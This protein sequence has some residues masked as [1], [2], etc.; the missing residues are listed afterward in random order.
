M[1]VILL[2]FAFSLLISIMLYS[3]FN[4]DSDRVILTLLTAI[5]FV[6]LGFITKETISNKKEELS[7]EF[8]VVAFFSIPSYLPMNIKLPYQHELWLCLQTLRPED[9]PAGIGEGG[10]KYFDALEYLIV[11]EIFKKFNQSWNV[12][13]K[14]TTMPEGKLLTFNPSDNPGKE[15]LLTE[16]LKYFSHNYFVR[17]D[18]RPRKNALLESQIKA[19]FPP[20]TEFSVEHDDRFKKT[21]I[22]ITNWYIKMNVTFSKSVS[23][24]GIGEYQKLMYG[25]T[26]PLKTVDQQQ[27]GTAVFMLKIDIEQTRL[28]NGHPDM[29]AHRNW[30]NSIVELLDNTFN[31]EQIREE[32]F[33]QFQLYGPEAIRAYYSTN[34]DFQS[35]S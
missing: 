24:L 25:T 6:T 35:G 15:V 16:F 33:R 32:H 4:R 17:P 22:S 21:I 28:L 20:N 13:A 1:K 34:K 8:P 14:Q 3:W 30:A 10:G 29:K 18:V 19:I 23:Y 31:Y 26:E 11:T 27:H 2:I 9:L 7:T 12:V 5:I